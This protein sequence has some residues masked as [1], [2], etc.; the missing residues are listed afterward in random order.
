[1]CLFVESLALRGGKCD[2]IEYHNA[3]FNRTRFE[4]LG[5]DDLLDLRDF[6]DPPDIPGLVKCRVLYSGDVESVT[7]EAY[8]RHTTRTLRLVRAD[9]IDYRYKYADKTAFDALLKLKGDADDILVVKRGRVTDTSFSNVLFY[10]GAKWLTP[11]EPLLFG[12][13]IARLLDEGRIER[14]DI[15][16]EDFKRFRR[17]MLVNAMMDM[18][19]GIVIEMG[20]VWA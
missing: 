10:D 8:R 5:R 2:G 6:I 12:T 4:V 15:R 9:D 20:N 13:R 3:R 14:A 7:C 16:P 19:D 17:A 11:A 1:M 18:D